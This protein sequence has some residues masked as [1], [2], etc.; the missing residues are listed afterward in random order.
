MHGR[1]WFVKNYF[2]ELQMRIP[3]GKEYFP[4]RLKSKLPKCKTVIAIAKA[5]SKPVETVRGWLNKGNR[6]DLDTFVEIAEILGVHTMW[7]YDGTGPVCKKKA[8]AIYQKHRT[9]QGGESCQ[10]S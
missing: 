9:T 4:E 1:P 10:T 2:E 7:L 3:K 5:V 6:P 8:E